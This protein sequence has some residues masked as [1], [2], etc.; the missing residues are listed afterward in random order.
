MSAGSL[1]EGLMDA[2]DD[3]ERALMANDLEALDRLLVPG[4]DTLRGDA[5]GLLVGHAVAGYRVGAGNP[6][7]LEA[8]P[9]P[10]HPRR[11]ALRRLPGR[12]AGP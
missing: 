6:D 11:P 4:P 1:P 10:H 2:F 9:N 12:R 5:A 3:Y 8:A 7:W